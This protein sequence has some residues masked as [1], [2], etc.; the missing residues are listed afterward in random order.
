MAF[1]VIAAILVTITVIR[2]RK[3]T[4]PIQQSKYPVKPTAPEPSSLT[5]LLLCD[6]SITC[7]TDRWGHHER[8]RVGQSLCADDYRFGVVNSS[9]VWQDCNTTQT[10]VLQSV[11]LSDPSR[12]E[13]AMTE[14]GVFELWN[15]DEQLWELESKFTSMIQPTS[16]CL[17]GRVVMDCPYLHLRKRGGN[18]V[19]NW[20]GVDGWKDRKVHESYPGLFPDDFS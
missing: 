1:L 4:S 12:L 2:S 16:Q 6:P 17:N 3:S 11:A 8:L 15:A 10:L 7:Q 9:L 20:Q 19:L 13:F 18:I 14:H 5:N